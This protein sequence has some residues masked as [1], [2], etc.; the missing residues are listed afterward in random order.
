MATDKRLESLI[1]NKLS[2]TKYDELKNSSNIKN[3]ELY[4]RKD[5]E[6]LGLPNYS[7][8]IPGYI[9]R[10]NSSGN[11]VE[12]SKEITAKAVA[13]ETLSEMVESLNNEIRGTY[14]L[15]QTIYIA[16]VD[17]PDFW[18]YSIEDT[19][20]TGT[21]PTKFD[22]Q[23]Y[24]FG[25]Y[26]LAKLEMTKI[27]SNA[28]ITYSDTQP[29]NPV[30]GDIWLTPTTAEFYD[31]PL[32]DETYSGKF[33]GIN[34]EGALGWIDVDVTDPSKFVLTTSQ[35]LTETQKAQARTNI[36]ATN[37]TYVNTQINNLI[38]SA[39][40]NLNTLGE[41]AAAI[42]SNQ[43]DISDLNTA[44]TK[45]QDKL[46]SG[47]N[48]K[49][50][51]G[52]SIIG[53]GNLTISIPSIEG[54]ATEAYV[55]TQIT[56]LVNSAPETMDTLGELAA[57]L[58]ENKDIVDTLNASIAS[59][60]DKLV[61]ATNIKTINGNSIL[62][63]GDLT[64]D[65]PS[66]EGDGLATVVYVDNQVT[67][68]NTAINKKQD[69]LVS[70]TNIKTINGTTLLGAGDLT[71]NIPSIEGLAT[72]DYV[73]TA[74]TGLASETYVNNKISA[75]NTSIASKQDTLVSGTNIKTINGTTLLGSGDL[76]IEIPSI[77]GLASETYVNNA[78]SGLASENY[79]T[80]EISTVNNSINKKQDKLVSGTNIKTI[81]GTTLLGAGD[82]TISIPSVEGLASEEYVNN[83]VSGLV[84]EDTLNKQIGAVNSYAASKQDKLVSGT[85]IKTINGNSIVGEGDL[86][87][88][89]PSIEGDGLATTEYV[90]N[91]ISAVNTSIGK[92]Q[93]TLVS[94]TN[95]KTINGNSIVG[96]GN[97]TIEIPSIEGLAT[98]TYVD[99]KVL[100]LKASISTKQ[101]TLVSGRNI[102]TINGTTI[103]GS[104]DLTIEIPSIEGLASETYVDNKISAVNTS[105]ASKQDKLV[106]GTNIKTIN[107]NNLLGSGNIVLN[108]PSIEGLASETYVNT[109]IANLINS[110]PETM[111]TLGELAAALQGNQEV[112]EALNSSIA[113]KQD[114]LVSGT[115]IKTINGSTILGSGD[116]T[117]E[118][119]SIEGLA[120]T[121]YVNTQINIVNSS[122]GK[123]Q[124]KLVSGTN[125]KT[126]NGTTL[127]G[128]GD[129]VLNIPSI[130]GLATETYVNTEISTVN[131][132][133]NK[134][135]DK[136]VS[137]TNIKTI[138]GNSIVGSGNLTITIPS[139][140]GL[141][142]ETY[143]NDAVASKQ[144]KLVSG[145]NIKTI[146]GN[147]LV[148][149]GNVTLNIPSI[150]GL[151]SETYVDNKI[152][153]VN[154]SIGKKQDTLVSGTNI[155][156]INGNSLLG[157]GNISITMPSLDNY[158]TQTY[159]NEKVSG[160]VS[161]DTLNSEVL[162]LKASIS[163]KQNT[164]VSGTNIKTINGNSLLGSG[165]VVLNIPSIEGLA[166]ETYV[167]NAVAG[168]ASTTY[169][170]GEISSVNTELNKKQNTLVSGTNIKTIN[171]TSLLG[172]D[173]IT[174]NS[175]PSLTGT[176]SSPGDLSTMLGVP[177]F[178]IS[179]VVSLNGI[180]YD[181]GTAEFLAEG[182]NSTTIRIMYAGISGSSSPYTLL[183]SYQGNLFLVSTTG[184][185]LTK[186][187]NILSKDSSTYGPKLYA[188]T[189]MGS[190]GQVL[191]SQGS[192]NTP[193]WMTPETST[194]SSYS[195]KIVRLTGSVT[196]S[197][198]LSDLNGVTITNLSNLDEGDIITF[199]FLAK[200]EVHRSGNNLSFYSA[201]E[202]GAS[203]FAFIKGQIRVIVSDSADEYTSDIRIMEHSPFGIDNT[204]GSK[205]FYLDNQVT[206]LQLSIP[207]SG[208]INYTDA[209]G[210]P[211]TFYDEAGGYDDTNLLPI[212]ITKATLEKSVEIVDESI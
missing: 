3:D 195:K 119:P 184:K 108:I 64:I 169:V 32:Y 13:F 44:L 133:I 69:K 76:T 149:S 123:K 71:L 92:K 187:V 42:T 33:L 211:Y 2:K 39:P 20:V 144:D 109:Q 128:S 183:K 165:N 53:S 84:T 49:T 40:D 23:F 11:D 113:S 85:N 192:E 18:I 164:L 86:F 46:V 54:L 29:L 67:T 203:T 140:E 80:V 180:K 6:I 96:S 56:N 35:T 50:I 143:V 124:D 57:A 19:A 197:P 21:V 201:Y 207:T 179:G 163:T 212:Y 12:W 142:T 135:Q 138:N 8:A 116:L 202:G 146:N 188:P 5:S 100:D 101:N 141:A 75:V 136:L 157:S 122:I 110:A 48:I 15:Y 159:V 61:S 112:V 132:S 134:K 193:V 131:N 156:T 190:A 153:A 111:D 139:I 81:N 34:S 171:G 147:S 73:N 118:I 10:V 78:V 28:N 1:I 158:A 120:T 137:G 121:S 91:K 129:I 117:I 43:E 63:S 89:I 105:I 205:I 47:T 65:I 83:A 172:S 88:S 7:S 95:I 104:G 99:N 60:Q 127:L 52:S 209:G 82:L 77:E 93:D 162:D 198:L 24:Q 177:L 204:D 145:T 115:N 194:G 22:D 175:V 189:S 4:I 178:T 62:G 196:E 176:S 161:E 125:I 154:T 114:K 191:T 148:G 102:K 74:V 182:S 27:V 98:E 107:G 31:L 186:S 151:A 58:Q 94:G 166:T 130:E 72:E 168:L 25:Y 199:D 126:I 51:N 103:L 170:D 87:I 160:L 150:D 200:G 16:E 38:N 155:K 206:Y 59:K 41:L 36:G 167:N 79:V 90:D 30:V 45:K 181:C 70:G 66:I 174:I 185:V 152:S 14:E 173:D 97:L 17:V 9:L 55:N 106:S 68:L 26:K 210:I 37:E 208:Q